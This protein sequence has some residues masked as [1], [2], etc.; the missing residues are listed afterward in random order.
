[1][2]SAVFVASLLASLAVAQ[3]HGH[4]HSHLHRRKEHGHNHKRGVVVEVVTETVYETVTALVDD[5]TTELIMP[6]TRSAKTTSSSSSSAAPSPSPGQFFEH[7]DTSSAV[8]PTPEAQSPPAVVQQVTY[9]PAAGAPLVSYS[10]TD[11][12][13]HG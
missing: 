8:A 6:K 3:P 12:T 5:S 11:M 1:M 13:F 10:S 4:G 9:V 7:S 2:K